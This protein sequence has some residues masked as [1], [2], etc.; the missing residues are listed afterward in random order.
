ML[1]SGRQSLFRVDHVSSLAKVIFC[2]TGEYRVPMNDEIRLG[3]IKYG[4][5]KDHVQVSFFV[6]YWRFM[7]R[8]IFV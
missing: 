1:L 8:S 5:L 3:C 2:G 6:E 7:Y 4:F